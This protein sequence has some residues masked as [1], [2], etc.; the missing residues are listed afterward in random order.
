MRYLMF[1]KHLQPL[2]IPEIGRIIKELGFSGVELTVRPGGH[3]QPD[4]VDTELPRAVEVF[5]ELGLDLPAI[6]V[7]IHRRDPDAEAVCR[8]AGRSGATVLRT[9]SQRYTAFGTIREQIARARADARQLEALG[10][11]YGVR[12]CVHCHSGDMLSAQGGILASIIDETDPRSVGVS[13]DVAHLT[14]EGGIAGWRQSIDLL[15]ERVGI[16]AVKS[17]GWF[18]EPDAVTGGQR[19]T[20]K[21]VPLDQ[22]TAQWRDALRLLRQVGWDA[23]GQALVSLHSEYQGGSSWRE[24]ALPELIDQTRRDVAW[25]QRQVQLAGAV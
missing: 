23:D 20:A 24:L 12:L 18:H 17:F 7:E 4:E 19:W 10:R 22:G 13:L 16:L 9:S 2:P 1:S 21:V 3:I 15:Q 11:E 5:G 14:V 8:A 25:L 6:V